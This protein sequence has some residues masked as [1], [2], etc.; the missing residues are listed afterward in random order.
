MKHVRM[1]DSDLEKFQHQILTDYIREKESRN[2]SIAQFC[3]NHKITYQQLKIVMCNLSLKVKPIIKKQEQE[4]GKIENQNFFYN[5]VSDRFAERS[6]EAIEVSLGLEHR[7][8]KAEDVAGVRIF[9]QM[10]Y[11]KFMT[12]I[13]ILNFEPTLCNLKIMGEIFEVLKKHGKEKS[14]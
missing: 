2:F 12:I 10:E 5:G 6:N 14:Y 9:E 7:E 4:G 1:P 11:S 8:C 13:S 3:I